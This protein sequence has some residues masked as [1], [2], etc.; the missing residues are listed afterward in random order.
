VSNS[1]RTEGSISNYD[2]LMWRVVQ[3]ISASRQSL[4]SSEPVSSKAR[5]AGNARSDCRYPIAADVIYQLIGHGKIVSEGRGRT[6][7]IS[8][9]GVLLET[10]DALPIGIR[11]AL[12]IAWPA[13]LDLDVRLALHLQGRTLRSDGNYTAIVIARHEF[14]T[15][16]QATSDEEAAAALFP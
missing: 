7:N 9:S 14:R 11:V 6:V 15:R 5:P 1:E 8:K 12:Q 2:P 10:E 16:K 3:K 13:K 4:M